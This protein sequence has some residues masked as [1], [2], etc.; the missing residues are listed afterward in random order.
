M[1]KRGRIVGLEGLNLNI[2][3]LGSQEVRNRISIL[4]LVK[5]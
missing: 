5:E 4:L 1:G 2:Q 3:L